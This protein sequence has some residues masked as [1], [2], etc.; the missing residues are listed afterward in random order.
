MFGQFSMESFSFYHREKVGIRGLNK[1]GK[2][3]E[4]HNNIYNYLIDLG[5]FYNLITNQ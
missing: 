1:T 3:S 4:N 2:T 5:V